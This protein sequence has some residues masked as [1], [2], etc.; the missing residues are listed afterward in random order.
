MVNGAKAMN[1]SSAAAIKEPKQQQQRNKRKTRNKVGHLLTA[2]LLL[3]TN[4][5]ITVDDELSECEE[6]E[7]NAN[8]NIKTTSTNNTTALEMSDSTSAIITNETLRQM[9]QDVEANLPITEKKLHPFRR[10]LDTVFSGYD[11]VTYLLNKKYANTRSSALHIGRRMGYEFGLFEHVN[12][13]YDLL[14]D[15]QILYRFT[16]VK[17]REV[18]EL[19]EEAT[20]IH[21]NNVHTEEQQQQDDCTTIYNID[22]I[23]DVFEEGVEVG[24]H[25]FHY[26][27]YKDTF[28][29]RDAVSF[30]VQH[31]LSKSR[32]DAVRIGNL[33]YER[34]IFRHCTDDHHHGGLKDKFLFY[35]FVPHKQRRHVMEKQTHNHAERMPIEA[36]ALRFKE[37]VR[38]NSDPHHPFRD[39]FCGSSAVDDL[40][41]GRLASTRF[42]AVTIG[43][44]L[45]ED[46]RLFRCV[47]D[48]HRP[49]MDNAHTYYQYNNHDTTSLHWL[50]DD[51]EEKNDEKT[52]LED[53]LSQTG[54]LEDDDL[55]DE[56]MGLGADSTSDNALT[57]PPKMEMKMSAFNMSMKM[58]ED[59]EEENDDMYLSGL[60]SVAT[61]DHNSSV[62]DALLS[63]DSTRYYDKYGF[64]VETNETMKDLQSSANDLHKKYIGCDLSEEEW[65]ELLDEC[66]TAHPGTVSKA[67]LT[68]LKHAMRLGLSDCHRQKA[69]TLITGVDI[70]MPEKA[71][72]YDNFVK[73]GFLA[74]SSSGVGNDTRSQNYIGVI[75][76]DLHRTFPRHILFSQ[77]RMASE[78]KF[79]C[80]SDSYSQVSNSISTSDTIT[81][82]G[83]FGGSNGPDA[84][85][86]ILYAYSIYDPE[87]VRLLLQIIAS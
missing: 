68:K 84:L 35:R 20:F 48:V 61:I 8:T 53:D 55:F 36:L 60:T 1:L 46:L 4:K 3:K 57:D 39:T 56:G 29:G 6:D 10:K 31:R 59:E 17:K 49:F 74:R 19:C 30:L 24:P 54:S 58:M 87:V 12:M 76:R 82:S 50:K 51:L 27:T 42:E 44:R 67:T 2:S 23:A 80:A 47:Y 65:G 11:L 77:S 45:A 34:G 62:V 15:K 81:N 9:A 73:Q 70:L 25:V 26:R 13:D 21:N 40:I 79:S 18:V 52:K 85:R 69:W 43:Q 16:P 14:D 86:R 5:P 72:E 22:Y 33:L 64:A 71:G 32:Q 83:E 7:Y 28:V 75:E 66:S 38:P 37:L 41:R 63:E 78:T